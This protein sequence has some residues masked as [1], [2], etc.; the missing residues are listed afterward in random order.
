M[1]IL[2]PVI[3]YQIG[4][5]IYFHNTTGRFDLSLPSFGASQSV[6]TC[7][8]NLKGASYAEDVHL[9]GD[10]S[11][12]FKI[13]YMFALSNRPSETGQVAWGQEGNATWSWASKYIDN[14]VKA[15]CQGPVTVNYDLSFVKNL[16][17]GSTVIPKP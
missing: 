3:I 17:H 2:T 8:E 5:Q 12:K 4:Y 14:D 9:E 10:N 15:R 16:F 1:L 13:N 11:V 7:A 6:R